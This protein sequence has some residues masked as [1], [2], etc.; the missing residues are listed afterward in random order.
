MLAHDSSDLNS[1]IENLRRQ[2]SLREGLGTTCPAVAATPFLSLGL[3]TN[4]ISA[5]MSRLVEHFNACLTATLPPS[6]C[7]VLLSVLKN[8]IGPLNTCF[9]S[10][11]G[12]DMIL[13][14]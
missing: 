4:W 13:L 11:Q 10:L 6:R 8:F 7:W 12:G 5:H 9:T 3:A 14:E 1:A 2:Y